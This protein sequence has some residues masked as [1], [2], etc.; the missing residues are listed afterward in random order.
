VT[1]V[2]SPTGRS[3]GGLKPV[4]KGTTRATNMRVAVLFLSSLALAT[5]LRLPT[6][7][8]GQPTTWSRRAA[9]ALPFVLPLAAT[10][11]TPLSASRSFS[12]REYVLDL[13]AARRGLDELTPLLER[14]EAK[15]YE[16]ARFLLRKPP[17]NGVR[18][19]RRPPDQTQACT[20]KPAAPLLPER[21]LTLAPGTNCQAASKIL[22]VLEGD[23]ERLPAKTK[24]CACA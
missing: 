16:E 19:A 11:S 7:A 8:S 6:A 14:R 21:T 18:K 2:S 3:G 5:G 17:V 4:L 1:K 15:G 22:I 12:V 20:P 24:D 23:K 9:C 13:K 10:A